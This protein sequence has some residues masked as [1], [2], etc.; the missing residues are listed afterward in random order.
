MLARTAERATA[1]T[2]RDAVRLVISAT[3]LV[4]V[5]TPDPVGRPLPAATLRRPG[6]AA[7][8]RAMSTRRARAS[9]RAR[10]RPSSSRPAARDGVPPQY[11]F[12][13]DK[14]Q[15]FAAQQVQAFETKVAPIDAAFKAVLTPAARQAALA[16]ALPELSTA[17]RTTLLGLD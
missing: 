4:A 12:T 7:R 8:H 6:R 13:A 2:R 1:F 17:A 3:I 5:V 14:G 16:A 11:D 15:Q 10:S 9:T